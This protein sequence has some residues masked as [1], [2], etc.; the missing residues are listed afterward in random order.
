[1]RGRALIVLAVAVAA[2]ACVALVVW[3][4]PFR[5]PQPDISAP[6]ASADAA[7]KGGYMTAARDAL[8]SI[9]PLPTDE[10]DL[11]RILKRAVAVSAAGDW[12]FLDD[13]AEKAVRANGRSARVRATAVWA[14]LRTG[15]VARARQLLSRGRLPAEV[16]D[17]LRG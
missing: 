17:L 10:D 16:G 14:S 2:A 4:R 8:S 7:L 6:L 12:A 9:T 15:D 11:M 3:L 13:M 5:G 1:M